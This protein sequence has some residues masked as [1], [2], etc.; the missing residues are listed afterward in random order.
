MKI[1]RSTTAIVL[2]T[3]AAVIAVSCGGRK[4]GK[5]TADGKIDAQAVAEKMVKEAEKLDAFSKAAAEYYMKKNGGLN[6][7]DILPDWSYTTEPEKNNFYG[8]DGK[9]IMRFV[10]PEGEE[11]SQEDYIAW[12]RKVYAATA[13]ISDDGFNI[14]GFE[15]ADDKETA[16]SEKPVDEMIEQSL[17]GWIYLGMYDW[18]Y[19]L[20][21]RMMR[22]W[23]NRNEKDNKYWA[24]IDVCRA[25]EKNMD[26]LFKD[27]E[28][29][30]E[31][32]DVQKALKE[33]AK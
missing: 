15:N 10:K 7:A 33:L 5:L 1:S 11:L 31:R 16:L 28:E 18:G 8:E 14:K 32:E 23:L 25:M 2:L 26:E 19:R 3:A 4:S 29:A 22:I 24:Q 27:A 9:S 6:P 30:L 13:K 21:G 12:V 17:G 20:D